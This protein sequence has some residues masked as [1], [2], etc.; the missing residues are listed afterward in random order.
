MAAWA[1]PSDPNVVH[2]QVQI[3]SPTSNILQILQSSPQAIINWNQFNIGTGELVHFLQ[4]DQF[5]SVLNR[6]TG[7]DPSVIQGML[8]SNGRVFLLNPNGILF[9]PGSQVDVG[10]FTAS[11][12]TMSDQDFLSG[13]MQLTQDPSRPLAALVNQ[14]EIRVSEGGFVVLVAPLLHQDGLIIAN[15][16]QVQLGAT[17][18]ASLS[19]DGQGLISF[20]IPDGFSP[21]FSNPGSQNGTILL[22][23][24]QVSDV[25]RQV[26][27]HPGILEA[28]SFQGNSLVGGEGLLIHSGQTRV[29]G[30]QQGGSIRLDSSKATVFTPGSTISANG[31]QAGG[32]A[33]VLSRGTTISAGNLSASSSAGQGGFAEV[34]GAHFALAGSIDVSGANGQH[35]EFLLDPGNLTI[36]QGAGPGTADGFLPSIVNA[37]GGLNES[38][39]T[40]AIAAVA[41]TV[42]LQATNNINYPNAT[43]FS[44]PNTRLNLSA[45]NHITI[46]SPNSLS[47]TLESLNLQAGGNIAINVPFETTIATSQGLTLQ[48]HSISHTGRT[49]EI[50]GAQGTRIQATGGNFTSQNSGALTLGGSNSLTELLAAG[51]VQLNAAGTTHLRGSRVELQ[52]GNN[53]V[54]SAPTLT[55]SSP[56]L[57]FNSGQDTQLSFN[58]INETTPSNLTIRA[59]RD[60]TVQ[61]F[62]S[63]S[64]VGLRQIDI[65]AQRDLT[66]RG[67]SSQSISTSAGIRLIAGRNASTNST[68]E[69]TLGVSGGSLNL[70]GQNVTVQGRTLSFISNNT[71][72][73]A[74]TGSLNVTNT[75]NLEISST[76]TPTQ[77]VAA[78]NLTL[79]TA[80]TTIMRGSQVRL[81]SGNQ[82]TIQTSTLNL[83]TPQFQS[84]SGLDQSL[85]LNTLNQLVPNNVSLSSGRD[86]SIRNNGTNIGI[87]ASNISFQAGRDLQLQSTSSATII[88]PNGIRLAAGRNVT[89]NSTFETTLSSVSGPLS[90]QGTNI[91]VQG[92]TLQLTGVNTSLNATT[93]SLNVQAT[94][95]SQFGVAGAP[96]QLAAAQNLTLNTSG[97]TTM[98]GSQIRLQ[99]GNQTTLQSSTLT[100]ETPQLQ[101]TSGH[102]QTLTLNT[103][104]QIIPGNVSLQSGRDLTLNNNGTN[105]NLSSDS[106]DLQ[107]TRD[108]SIQSSSSTSFST[109]NGARL[110]AGRN[111]T[112]NSTFDTSI[113]SPNQRLL[114]QG[115]NVN[116]QTR[117][118]TLTGA[119][120]TLNAT[121]GSLN[122]Q[123]TGSSSFGVAGTPTQL[124]AAQNLTLNTAGTTTMRGSQVRLQAGNHSTFQSPTL[125]LETP[126]FRSTSG[127]DQTLT[128]NTLN[129]I[130]PGDISI[131]SGRDLRLANFSSNLDVSAL[132][133]ELQA[134]RDLSIDSSSSATIVAPN[135]IRLNA[136]GNVTLSS[137][138]D[139]SFSSANGPLLV[140]GQTING[141]HR[142]INI[143]GSNT[144]LN[145]T[146]GSLNLQS[147]GSSI[148]GIAGTPT[149]LAAAQNL[150]LNAAGSTTMSGSQVRLQAGNTTTLQAGTLTRN[151]PQFQ[152][153][154]GQDQVLTL[155][156]LNQASPGNV[157]LSAGRDLS[158]SSNGANLS[159]S[160]QSL[161]L[162]AGRDL[163]VN[164]SS[165]TTLNSVD[166]IRLAAG[167]NVTMT[168]TFDTALTATN[169]QVTIQGQA[170]DLQMR[171]GN[172]SG[173]TTRLEASSGNLNLGATGSLQIG[174]TGGPTTIS[175]SRDLNLSSNSNTNLLGTQL[176][177]Q[178]GNQ[179]S[180]RAS[181][182]ILDAPE[183]RMTSG[184][185]QLLNINGI[186]QANPSNLTLRSGGSL[187]MT[188]TVN[189]DISLNGFDAQAENNLQ[190][191]SPFSLSITAPTGV[192]LAGGNNTRL[193]T[194]F[195]QTLN[196]TSGV[197]V[198]GANISASGRSA[199]FT[200][201]TN[202]SLLA[203]QDL[204]LAP[205]NS[206]NLSAPGI[207]LSGALQTNNALFNAGSTGLVL[208][209]NSNLDTTGARLLSSSSIT[210]NATNNLNVNQINS[211]NVNLMGG[212]ISLTSV[213][214][215][216]GGNY[217]LITPGNLTERVPVTNATAPTL[218]SLNISAGRIFGTGTNTSFSIP[219]TSSGLANISVT[220][221]NDTALQAS[222]SM[223]QYSGV[224]VSLNTTPQTGDIYVDGVL[225]FRGQPPPPPP[226]PPPPVVPPEP[227]PEV[228]PGLTPEQR[229]QI[230]VQSN[231]ALGNLGS[232]SRVLE[233]EERQHLSIR[234][235]S[236]TQT[237]PQDPFSPTLA[238]VMPEPLPPISR[239][240]WLLIESLLTVT[241]PESNDKD[242]AAFNAMVD[243]E[244]RE[245]WEIRYWRRLLEGL[246]LWQDN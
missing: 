93:G 128:F 85:T 111:V 236:L 45:G 193:Q 70:Q 123:S 47:L 177:V 60:V 203:Q 189:L 81:Q 86:L 204:T 171:N 130:S 66:I 2:G 22:T 23:P 212:N 63:N 12:L 96:T 25:F 170:L 173:P 185:D 8:R 108:L 218:G 168:S 229:S 91:Q 89:T 9:G 40:N 56:Q 224:N 239:E 157:N 241:S 205:F 59:G 142:N 151:T 41:G 231:L 116:V 5:A 64:N 131:Q 78:Q 154:A 132:S 127:Q 24:G 84:T 135:G 43:G 200:S 113:N 95:D 155:N 243:Q 107:A 233:P 182:I 184:Q 125:T 186:S 188:S 10:S 106:L 208:S 30:Q 120:T 55:S 139:V 183:A 4:P 158:L 71:S 105:L 175:A 213:G 80:G 15:S 100:L 6:V 39:S 29:D 195:D 162:Q 58:I 114:I 187:N 11:T 159:F 26:V 37:T 216:S 90:L 217:T 3:Q 16:G 230:L 209:S 197:L 232:F 202:V 210:A 126:E 72:L 245:I 54:A 50:S 33:L 134:V 20:A 104:N 181:S 103:L 42:T 83:D 194:S 53:I 35:G 133:L 192:R 97:T 137:V 149:Q 163:K 57:N 73:N 140:Q 206:F 178:S 174:D 99:A 27:A 152:S 225:I 65:E 75:G 112:T 147:T 36:V 21:S 207:E 244:V 110:T 87:S 136:G 227:L 167:R 32:Q 49:T 223:F 122:L 153:S 129:Q 18:Q 164:S 77:L 176:L 222:A 169:N 201:S 198:S 48:G 121:T 118:L 92:R 14:G 52:A 179:T 19:V 228:E 82:T 68:F 117:N 221:G 235:E 76:T 190:I 94:G 234:T 161:E 150:T 143:S 238:L 67:T 79:N 240:E 165:S 242:R 246:I 101:S 109:P 214:N 226:D 13:R 219:D 166:G 144:S 199:N 69:T 28:N 141:Q 51:D 46:T 148:F 115:E 196:S 31:V 61:N 138:F 215:I 102:D 88:A 44:A 146:T 191:T 74:T 160:G 98:R 211:P 119:N 237:F 17:R 1:L 220:A 145:A 34:S 38:V 172:F 156:T 124:A 180:L 7:L 62:N